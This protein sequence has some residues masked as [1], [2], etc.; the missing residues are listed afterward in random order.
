MTKQEH[1]WSNNKKTMVKSQS[2]PNQ[3]PINCETEE[4]K[5]AILMFKKK[6]KVN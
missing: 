2:N 4:T 5:V 6:V 3:E 1:I